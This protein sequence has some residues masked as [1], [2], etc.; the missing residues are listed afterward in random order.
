V[1]FREVY[2]MN[3]VAEV[4]GCRFA[5]RLVPIEH[6]NMLV[7][8]TVESERPAARPGKKVNVG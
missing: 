6:R 1:V 5:R 3:N 7:V 8:S 2:A 4:C